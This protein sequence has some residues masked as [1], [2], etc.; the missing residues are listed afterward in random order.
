MNNF[1]KIKIREFVILA[2]TK[3]HMRDKGVE[4]FDR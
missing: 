3:S 1:S 2:K 4:N